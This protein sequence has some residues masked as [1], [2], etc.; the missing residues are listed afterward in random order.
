MHSLFVKQ[1]LK[2]WSVCNI[3]SHKY[4]ID[5][6]KAVLEPCPQLE[7]NIW[8]KEEPKTIEQQSKVRGKDI[9]QDQLFKGD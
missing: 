3:I 9:S 4:W 6:V 1:I 2:S 7:W 8:F 5:S